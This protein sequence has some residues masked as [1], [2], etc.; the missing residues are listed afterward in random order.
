MRKKKDKGKISDGY[1]TFD[2]LYEHR[3]ALFLYILKHGNYRAAE[4]Q[5]NHYAG[6]DLIKLCLAATGEQISYH[7]P[8]RLRRFWKP[9]VPIWTLNDPVAP[10]LLWDGHT[11]KQVVLRLKRSLRRTGR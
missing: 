1:H 11:S 5:L 4:A 6:W 9:H 7:L 8:K 10:E 3:H 2:D